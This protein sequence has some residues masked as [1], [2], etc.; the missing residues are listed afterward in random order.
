[1]VVAR[2]D[3]V[4]MHELDVVGRGH[5]QKHRALDRLTRVHPLDEPIARSPA[6]FGC[7]PGVV[8]PRS[9]TRC[10]FRGVNA[11][12]R[13]ET[14]GLL[15]WTRSG[16]PW[17]SP[18]DARVSFRAQAAVRLPAAARSQ[19]RITRGP[20][21]SITLCTRETVGWPGSAPSAA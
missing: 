8:A 3:R 13:P 20:H 15:L 21:P 9:V 16:H 10:R 14:H 12:L 2:R 7:L 5:R 18:P 6:R 4:A 11:I 17:T 1:R 19:L